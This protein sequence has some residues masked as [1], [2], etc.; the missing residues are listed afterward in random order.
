MKKLI[1]ILFIPF[2]VS[3]TDRAATVNTASV[4]IICD[5][6]SIVER[7]ENKEIICYRQRFV[8][9]AMTCKWKGAK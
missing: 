5:G 8:D 3:C 7:C 9:A 1:L 4:F 2:L 6:N